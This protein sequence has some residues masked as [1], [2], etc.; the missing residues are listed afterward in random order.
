MRERGKTKEKASS[1]GR[2]WGLSGKQLLDR[3]IP[4]NSEF[5][6]IQGGAETLRRPAVPGKNLYFVPVRLH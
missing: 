5:P 1:P 4:E 2:E 6:V 3:G